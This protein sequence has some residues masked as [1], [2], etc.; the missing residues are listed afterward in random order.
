MADN[1]MGRPRKYDSPEKM[2]ESIDNYFENT[3]K[4]T[5]C[6]LA[7]YLGFDSRVSLLNYEGYSEDFLSTIK[8]AKSRIEEYYE[9]HLIGSNAAGP[10]FALKN[11]KWSDKQEIEHSGNPQKPVMVTLGEIL[12]DSTKPSQ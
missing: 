9:Q 3:T 12:E 2:Q 11:F 6:G 1:K 8:K 10:I 4:L 7:L 5:I